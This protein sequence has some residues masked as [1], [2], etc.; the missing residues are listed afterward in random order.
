MAN[1]KLTHNMRFFKVGDV[2]KD[3]ERQLINILQD[4]INE[5][6]SENPD[7]ETLSL[8]HA[9]FMHLKFALEELGREV[10]CTPMM[11]RG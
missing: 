2:K 3:Y 9:E 11:L 5:T 1:V 10:R 4:W 7:Q 8:L 6:F